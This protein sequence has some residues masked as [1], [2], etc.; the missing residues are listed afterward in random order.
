LFA[1]FSDKALVS[2]SDDQRKPVAARWVATVPHALPANLYTFS[3]D[4][5]DG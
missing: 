1:E 3:P 5:A 4:G 2:V